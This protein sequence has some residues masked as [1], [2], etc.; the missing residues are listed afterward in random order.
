[1][2][3]VVVIGVAFLRSRRERG[4]RRDLAPPGSPP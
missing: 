2:I 3:V 4:E 1:M